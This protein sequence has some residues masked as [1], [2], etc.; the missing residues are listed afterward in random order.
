VC[1]AQM[2]HR[3]YS[4]L[5]MQQRLQHLLLVHANGTDYSFTRYD[6]IVVHFVR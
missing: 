4:S 6:D 3:A 5:P 2:L 1:R